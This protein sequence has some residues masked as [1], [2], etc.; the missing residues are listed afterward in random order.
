[1]SHLIHQKHSLTRKRKKALGKYELIAI[2]LGGMIGG[3]IFSVLGVSVQIV[4][5]ATPLAL[6]LGGL[7][8]FFAA[9]SYAKLAV[10]YKDEG[11]T[12]SFFKKTFPNNHFSASIVGWLISFGYIS[13]LALYAFT[14]SSYFSS[15]LP[16]SDY[17]LFKKIVAGGIILIFTI[18]NILSVKGMGKIEDIMVYTKVIVLVVISTL[19]ISKGNFEGIQP[20]FG[21]K[22]SPSSLLI[23]ASITFVAYEGF[24]LVINAYHES[25]D[26]DKNV[27]SAIYWAIFAVALIYIVLAIAALCAIPH[28]Q[29]IQ[30]KEYALASGASQL[31]GQAGYLSVV[32]GALL[33][34]SSAISGT[35]FGASRQMARIADDGFFPKILCKRRKV[36][37]PT[38]SLITMAV[39]SY[40]F[41]LSGSLQSILEFGSIT[42][43]LVSFLMSFANFKIRKK[44]KAHPMVTIVAMLGLLTGCIVI[45]YFEATHNPMQ[46]A[47]TFGI[48]AILIV[49]AW[50]YSRFFNRVNQ[51]SR[52]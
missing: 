32:L 10:Y 29:I 36:H 9:Y 17:H 25:E 45:F 22:F 1:M 27:P 51:N 7:L 21:E 8:A 37:I 42:F 13:T 24:Q 4:G 23:V 43:I 14:F 15:L 49:M 5:T 35:L 6:A 40:L 39:F 52:L 33:A 30:N 3:G 44:T 18:I 20:F 46:L 47:Y 34:T 11:A 31:L 50:L 28:D 2:A 19:F 48:Y 41:V 38:Y 26:P 12:Y 16:A